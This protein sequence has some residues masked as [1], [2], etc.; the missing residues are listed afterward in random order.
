M[1]SVL[2]KVAEDPSY[3]NVG[4]CN[5]NMELN[6]RHSISGI[7]TFLFYKDGE[8]IDRSVGLQTKN[9]VKS[10]LNSSLNK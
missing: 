6:V 2:E 3:K 5:K 7:P 9:T 1:D 10:M 8:I 4:K